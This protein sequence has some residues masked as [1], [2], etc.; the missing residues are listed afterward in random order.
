LQVAAIGERTKERMSMATWIVCGQVIVE[1]TTN[2]A[3]KFLFRKKVEPFTAR[4]LI[5]FM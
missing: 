2:T 3:A 4:L 5:E 1:Y